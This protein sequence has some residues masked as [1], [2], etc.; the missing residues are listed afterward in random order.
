M[1]GVLEATGKPSAGPPSAITDRLLRD[2]GSSL[3]GG[4]VLSWL[5]PRGARCGTLML[6]PA[7]RGDADGEG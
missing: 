4:V 7:L 1:R 3:E 5:L 2:A 6:T